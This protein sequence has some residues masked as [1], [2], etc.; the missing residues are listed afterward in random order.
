M[1]TDSYIHTY[2]HTYVHKYLALAG[3]CSFLNGSCTWGMC[4]SLLHTV[5]IQGMNMSSNQHL[6]KGGSSGGR[7]EG[8]REGGREAD[9]EE[10]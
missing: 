2:I 9:R 4:F 7:E 5:A 10:N 6:R 3:V 1:N 8:E